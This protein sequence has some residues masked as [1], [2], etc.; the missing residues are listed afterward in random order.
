MAASHTLA[1]HLWTGLGDSNVLDTLAQTGALA[2]DH[3]LMQPGEIV[4]I[5]QPTRD[6]IACVRVTLGAIRALDEN[7]PARGKLLYALNTA[8]KDFGDAR[9]VR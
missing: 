5:D 6:F 1:L 4:Q 8:F 9:T 3:L 2:R 7:V